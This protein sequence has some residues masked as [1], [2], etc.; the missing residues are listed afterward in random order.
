A[1]ML[2]LLAW[3]GATEEV[4]VGDLLIERPW[5][6]ATPAGA[7]VAGGYMVITNAGQEPD[8]LVGGIAPFA[9][10]I[11]IHEMA[12]EGGV[13]RMRPL[14]EGLEIPAGGSV[15]LEP[16]GYHVMFM[17]LQEPLVEGEDRT[18][19][20]EFRKAGTVDLDFAVAP[21]GARAPR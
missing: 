12:M 10:R 17:D 18:A 9:G 11:E 7:R 14:A 16:G 4:R 1:A 3:P 6:R 5:S 21:M 2:A 15:T 13:M 8:R 19:T 20:L